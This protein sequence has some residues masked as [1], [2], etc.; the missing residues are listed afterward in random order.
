MRKKKKPEFLKNG[1]AVIS[2][3]VVNRNHCGTGRVFP[4]TCGLVS[5]RC[6]S[7]VSKSASD[8]NHTF[9][10]F[11]KPEAM[12]FRD[13]KRETLIDLKFVFYWV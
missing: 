8:L 11:L 10:L 3:P 1:R 13:E 6:V 7:L 5:W 4:N 2:N 9:A 12:G